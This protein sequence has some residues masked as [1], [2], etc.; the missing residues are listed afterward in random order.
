MNGLTLDH[1]FKRGLRLVKGDIYVFNGVEHCIKSDAE[2]EAVNRGANDDNK[3]VIQSLVARKNKGE[4]PCENDVPVIISWKVNT[5]GV[6]NELAT[7]LEWATRSMVDTANSCEIKW[8]T[9]SYG[10]ASVDCWCPN[11]E[12][13]V[14]TQDKHNRKAASK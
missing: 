12:E 3:R 4:Q 10:V 11:I 14:K 8:A 2:L 5:D 7:Q 13:L 9:G 6:S 1:F